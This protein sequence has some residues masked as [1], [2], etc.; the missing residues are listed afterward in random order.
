MEHISSM[1][2]AALLTP[3]RGSLGSQNSNTPRVLL[4]NKTLVSLQQAFSQV[5][6]S[7]PTLYI[8]DKEN[9]S[10]EEAKE[11]AGENGQKGGE[12]K[13]NQGQHCHHQK[14]LQGSGKSCIKNDTLGSFLLDLA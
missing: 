13:E 2:A 8:R 14:Q 7:M 9:M 1:G 10:Q 3:S 12:G 4:G 6:V 5:T 11:L